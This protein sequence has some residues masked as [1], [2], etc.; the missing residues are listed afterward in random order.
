MDTESPAKTDKMLDN[1]FGGRRFLAALAELCRCS[2]HLSCPRG[3]R[4][5]RRRLIETT[6]TVYSACMVLC[7]GSLAQ[8][9][10]ARASH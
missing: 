3:R 5:D 4:L 1:P 2:S 7:L 8:L 9:V 10:T 6:V